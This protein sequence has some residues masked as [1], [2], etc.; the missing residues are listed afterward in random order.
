MLFTSYEFILFLLIVFVLYYA[1][2]K[3]C[4]WPLLLLASYVFYLFS[5]PSNLLYILFTTVTTYLIV[6]RIQKQRDIQ[7]AY[8]AEHKKELSRDERKAYKEIQKRSSGGCC[9]WF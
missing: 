9:C 5:G 3:K 8:L 7:S 4:Q 6:G 2:P 1:L